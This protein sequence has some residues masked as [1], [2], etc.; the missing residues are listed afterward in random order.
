M[1]TQQRLLETRELRFVEV[2][3][4]AIRATAVDLCTALDH[5]HYYRTTEA[6]MSHAPTALFV[7]KGV[8]VFGVF[9]ISVF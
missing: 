3:E 9:Q 1:S 7:E 6:L 8:K 5:S 2:S 4:R